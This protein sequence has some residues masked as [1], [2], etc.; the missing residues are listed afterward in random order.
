MERVRRRLKAAEDGDRQMIL[1]MTTVL[2]DGLDAV[3]TDC[4]QACAENVYSSAHPPATPVAT[5]SWTIR[6]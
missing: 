4:Q 5:P 1:I 3:E 6:H 2:S